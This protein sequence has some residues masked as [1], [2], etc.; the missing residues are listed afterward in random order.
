MPRNNDELM[1]PFNQ[2]IDGSDNIQIGTLN[3]DIGL[4]R[5]FPSLLAQVVPRLAGKYPSSESPAD[6]YE[7]LTKLQHNHVNGYRKW[8]EDYGQIG[9]VV[10]TVYNEFDAQNFGGRVRILNR[11]KNLYDDLKAEFHSQRPNDDVLTV[12]RDRADAIIE[13]IYIQIRN[14]IREMATGIFAEDIEHCARAVVCH[15]FINCKILEKP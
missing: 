10:D 12:L 1:L 9:A 14:E 8:I 4:S 5:R 2:K 13:R 6:S 11:F 15:A 7:V 3:G